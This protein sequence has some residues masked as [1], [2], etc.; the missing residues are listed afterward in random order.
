[1]L[2][3]AP[4]TASAFAQS[5]APQGGSPSPFGYPDVVKRAHDLAGAPYD[6]TVPALPDGLD[7]LD[8]DAWRDIRF[9]SD[10]PLLDQQLNA[11]FR[12]EL[13]HLGHLYK[14]PVVVNV[15]RDGI[16]A[17]IP[18]AANLFDYGRNKIGPNLPINLGFAGFR[19]RYPINAPHVW[20]EVVSFL[21]ASYFRFLGRGQR[22]G[23]SARGLA[24]GAGPR[25]NEEF[26]FF[27]E[28]WIETPDPTA[29]TIVIYALLDGESA[30]G[31]FRFLLVPG[32]A[33]TIEANVTLFARKPIPAIG[34]A[35]LSS[36]FFVGKND[37]RFSD[38]F[39]SELH[40]FG[41]APDAY[42]R[43]G[44][45]L[46]A[47]QQSGQSRSVGVSRPR[48]ARLRAF[49]ARPQ[50]QRLSGPRARLRAAAEL[51]DRAARRLG[52]G[53]GGAAR[54]CRPATRPTTIS[55]RPGPPRRGWTP[56]SR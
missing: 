31:A 11:T 13:F 37:H 35:P 32:Q 10:K 9:K 24:I 56:A 14:R 43:R 3:G 34:L 20:D 22:Y 33:T 36:M 25:L 45:D 5:D 54:N 44:V 6:A 51:L 46:A 30:T 50:L 42:R 29:D 21:G 47:A 48:P 2:A 16:P 12:L 26:P 53:P 7:D 49:A 15:L 27:R 38:D 8:Y 52:R 17:P 41:R 40:D 39:R 23:L 4:L 28:F 18:Y 55:W 1:M 19:L